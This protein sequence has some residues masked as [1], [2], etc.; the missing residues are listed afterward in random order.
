[1]S[2]LTEIKD[3]VGEYAK[4]IASFVD[5]E[6][7]I[8]DENMLR[9]AATGKFERIVGK[10]SKGAIYKDVLLNGESHVIENPSKHRLCSNCDFKDR[11]Q[12][13][14]EIA[15]PIIHNEKVIGVIG[16]V[17]LTD[18][19]KYK[20]L[21]NVTLYLDF[22]EQISDFMSETISEKE[23]GTPEERMDILVNVIKS[24]D[25]CALILDKDEKV[26]SINEKAK[27]ELKIDG[28]N[29]KLEDISIVSTEEIMFG[30]KVFKIKNKEKEFEV[31]GIYVPI[32]LITK[33]ECSIFFFAKYRI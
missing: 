28:E 20:V 7:E 15:A 27:R 4:I 16:I 25:K 19:I 8:V 33:K 3:E 22:T 12:E 29:E 23:K 11:C 30:K 26:L 13:K 17:A 31:V 6:V 24:F 2:F 32:S 1:M 5:C 9:I 21:K 14:L 18:I 10:V